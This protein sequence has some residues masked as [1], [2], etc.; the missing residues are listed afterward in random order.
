MNKKLKYILLLFLLLI[1]CIFLSCTEEAITDL[2]LKPISN[3]GPDQLV[4][5]FDTVYL[6]GSQS[7]TSENA[8]YIWS[9]NYKPVGSKV[10]FSDSS[11]SNPTFVP[12]VVGFFS[13]QLVTHEGDYYSDPDYTVVQSV[14]R[15][16]D[17]YFPNSIGSNWVYKT[18]NSLANGEGSLTSEIVGETTLMNNNPATIWVSDINTPIGFYNTIDTLYFSVSKDTVFYYKSRENLSFPA[19]LYVLPYTVGDTVLDLSSGIKYIVE[20][21]SQISLGVGTFKA[22][23]KIR[24]NRWGPNY[25]LITYSWIVPNIGLIKRDIFEY[26]FGYLNYEEHWELIYYNLVE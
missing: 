14:F 23:F 19:I 25:D 11:A 21:E 17:Q 12:D 5:I 6:D 1:F 26:V 24:E 7:I 4:E 13:A 15:Y 16:S 3:A 9:F 18:S 8:D 10:K 20:E 22:G 2:A